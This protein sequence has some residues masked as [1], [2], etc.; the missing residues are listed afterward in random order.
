MP[1]PL[2]QI[3][4]YP[5]LD[6]LVRKLA[7]VEA[8]IEP[9][10][11][12][13]V[14]CF[15]RDRT[16][17]PGLQ[18]KKKSFELRNRRPACDLSEIAAVLSRRAVRHLAGKLRKFSRFVTQAGKSCLRPGFGFRHRGCIIRIGS[19]QNVRRLQEIRAAEALR[20]LRIVLAAVFLGRL[21]RPDFG[22]DQ[23]PDQRLLGSLDKLAGRIDDRRRFTDTRPL[24]LREQQGSDQ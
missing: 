16:D 2:P 18:G 8:L 23:S 3:G 15:Y 7:A 5:R 6:S 20:V 17:L 24:C 22:V 9:R 19:E 12:I 21:G 10:N 1:V 11:V 13:T 4:H 14:T